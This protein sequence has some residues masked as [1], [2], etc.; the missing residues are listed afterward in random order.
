MIDEQNPRKSKCIRCNT[1]DA[2]ACVVQAKSDAHVVCVDPALDTG[3]VT[4]ITGAFVTRLETDA[5]GRVVKKVIAERDSA[6]AEYSA[7]VVV[8]SAGAL[9]SAA[10]LLRSA[11]D[12]YPD[13]LANSSGMVGRNYVCHQNSTFLAVSKPNAPR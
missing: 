2:F 9:N 8:V 10:I 11:S 3:N 1:C 7:D 12:K 6:T 4:L 13:G 5:S